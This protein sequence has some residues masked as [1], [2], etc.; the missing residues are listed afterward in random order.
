M[1]SVRKV[2]GQALLEACRVA[3]ELTGKSINALPEYF[4]SV[5]T[6]EYVNEYF[7]TFIF[8]MEDSLLSLCEE[9][10]I[11]Y[12][13]ADP[14][15]RINK[16]TRA[17]L[18][19]KDFKNNKIK[20][21]VEFKRSLHNSQ[22]KK[23]ALR[24]AWLCASAPIG[25]RVEKN[26]LVAVS[27]RNDEYFN[28]MTEKIKFWVEEEIKNI[29]VTFE[30]VDISDFQSTRENTVGSDLYGGVWEFKYQY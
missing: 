1:R 6:A 10:G 26:Y 8:S 3:D 27:T 9:I 13:E 5:K 25:H 21:V 29:K 7:S 16:N 23:D 12:E 19:L 28:N 24:L 15:F 4:L 20:H 22:I 18:V 2:L 14:K 11:Y 17:D 30:S